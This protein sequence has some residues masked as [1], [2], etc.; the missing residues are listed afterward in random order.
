MHARLAFSSILCSLDR[1]FFPCLLKD[2]DFPGFIIRKEDELL[3]STS[4]SVEE[5]FALMF[6]VKAFDLLTCWAPLSLFMSH[7]PK[8]SL[9]LFSA[10]RSRDPS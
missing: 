1:S 6:A 8:V 2:D 10:I 5:S 4:L 3:L 7:Q 9:S